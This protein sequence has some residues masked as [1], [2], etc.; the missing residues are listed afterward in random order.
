MSKDQRLQGYEYADVEWMTWQMTWL[1]TVQAADWTD[2]VASQPDPFYRSR[3]KERGARTARWCAWA[4][5]TSARV[6]SCG[7]A[8]R[9]FFAGVSTVDSSGFPLQDGMFKN[10]FGEL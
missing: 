3:A 9:R 6:G 2:D 7:H 5:W 4:V 1:L 10:T 8:G